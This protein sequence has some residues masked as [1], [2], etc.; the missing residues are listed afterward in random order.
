MHCA[1]SILLMTS[2]LV[3]WQEFQESKVE[4]EPANPDNVETQI[5]SDS[6]MPDSGAVF[7]HACS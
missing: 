7:E 2:L 5:T 4:K 3:Q 1:I 6:C